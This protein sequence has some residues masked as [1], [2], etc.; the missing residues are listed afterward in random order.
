MDAVVVV[1]STEEVELVD[2]EAV[3]VEVVVVLVLTGPGKY[4]VVLKVV[5]DQVVRSEQVFHQG[6]QVVLVVSVTASLHQ[7]D[8][9]LAF[10]FSRYS[11]L[12]PTWWPL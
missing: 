5:Q 10:T 9:A 12:Y 4:V 8:S 2:V 7:E 6:H 3:V 11:R 1:E